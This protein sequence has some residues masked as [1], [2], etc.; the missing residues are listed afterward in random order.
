MIAQM[1]HFLI[2]P[3]F[4]DHD[5]S[6][7]AVLLHFLSL[8]VL[9]VAILGTT[10][11]VINGVTISQVL[12]RFLMVT[13]LCI[14]TQFLMR[15]G[16]VGLSSLLFTAL[17][18]VF[19]IISTLLFGSVRSPAFANFLPALVVS[20]LL[21][22]RKGS[23]WGLGFAFVA[24]ASLT[25]LETRGLLP[26]SNAQLTAVG[27]FIGITAGMGLVTVLLELNRTRLNEVLAQL[28]AAN[29][30]LQTAG[31]SLER[32]VIER[33]KALTTSIEVSRRLSTILDQGQLL[34]EV[35]AQ[36][37]GAFNY[38]HVHIYLWD[39]EQEN[40]LMVEGSGEVGQTLLREEHK[41]AAGKGLVGRA[42]ITNTAVLISDVTQD[43]TWLPNPHLPNTKA[44]IAVAI[45]V[46]NEVLG[47]LDVQHNV[48]N[49]LTQID[50]DLLQSIAGQIAVALQNAQRYEEIQQRTR[51]IEESTNFLDSVLENLPMMLFVKDAEKLQ[52][53]RFNKAGEELVGINRNEFLGK[54]DYDFFPK[55]EAD[56][57]VSKDREVLAGQE[58][59]DIPEEPI[60]TDHQGTRILHTRKVPILDRDGKPQ[61]LLGISEDITEQ[62]L[63]EEQLE[64]RIQQLNLL[65]E[66]GHKAEETDSIP[67][68]LQWVSDRLVTAVRHQET[69]I[70]AITLDDQLYGNEQAIHLPRQ[71][72]EGLR[73]SGELVGRIYIAYKSEHDF[74][75]EESALLGSISQRVA[76]YIETQRLIQR[77]R[78]LAA[79]VEN[80][81]DF[82]G[83]GSLAGE[84]LYVN[85]A[86]LQM[87]G[88][89]PDYAL[90]GMDASDFYPPKDAV[91]LIEE[92]I[93]AA[94]QSGSW[95]DE[96]QLLRVD[97]STLPVEETIGVNYDANNQPI[98]FSITMRDITER[99]Q[100]AEILT[101]QATE[102]QTVTEVGTAVAT[103]NDTAQLLQT[104]VNL[105]QSGFN[106]YYAQIFLV[107]VLN[108]VLQMTAGSGEIGKELLQE[109]LIIPMRSAKSLIAQAANMRQGIVASDV[110]SV[111][112]Y[113]PHPL[114]PNTH[115]EIAIPLVAGNTVLGVLDVQADEIGYFSTADLPVYT[116]LAAQVA[117]A[118]QNARQYEET[119][120]AL[121]E[122][123]TLQRNLT[124]EGWQA[125]MTA[126]KR[127]IRGYHAHQNKVDALETVQETDMDVTTIPVTVLG[128]SIGGLTVRG[129][130]S[131]E[132]QTLLDAISQQVGQALERSRL[133]EQTQVALSETEQQAHRLALL[134]QMSAILNAATSL[135]EVYEIAAEQTAE[136][137]GAD[138][139]SLPLLTQDRKNLMIAAFYGEAYEATTGT[140]IPLAEPMKTAI[141]K[142]QVIKTS[143]SGLIRSVL[144]APLYV[145]GQV[146][147]TINVGS[148]RP[149]AYQM[150]DENLM[151][152]V[153]SLLAARLE[154]LRLFRAAQARAD[155]ERRVRTIT[156]KIRQATNREQILQVAQQE[157]GEMLGAKKTAV[158]LGTKQ[159]L[160]N[161]IANVKDPSPD[162]SSPER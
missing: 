161:H 77:T 112:E 132:N 138:R 131:V 122:V 90:E 89:T 56:F 81:P 12:P 17:L 108:D 137:L 38:Y 37:R 160:L 128:Q 97:G 4:D 79:I 158:H 76:N 62:K 103:I 85:P 130:I 144:V 98:S 52:F 114:L 55:E 1:R 156:D 151:L 41:V 58:L 127:P 71:I 116:A 5:K 100:T 150:R 11:A 3:P 102:L 117:V 152:Q 60:H 129:N 33:T 154:N 121:A 87:M 64:S 105:T 19:L 34:E 68:F 28:Q 31:A 125:F 109:N 143:P 95:S 8:T 9:A 93:P 48:L 29:S 22:G 45:S 74:G 70:T 65:S 86:G 23:L 104:V 141:E 126:R 30:Q 140:I 118:L 21:F 18:W 146:I 16:Q 51:E 80:H 25:T 94:L 2:P 69:C 27:M 134:N 73:V 72:V 36:L 148:K 113:L 32:R 83:V 88:Y 147:G 24:G 110:H 119:Q 40:L 42:A 101:K 57:F 10:A 67:Q 84:A 107:D 20:T 50:A 14:L 66:I 49:G 59:I 124:R 139:V 133:A 106:L 142:L 78:L 111:P 120:R 15:R 47:V 44:E 7:R 155:R 75:D 46:G 91:K 153:T 149:N 6:R 82:I 39:D 54:S 35:V 162:N 135:E 145:S 136:I 99:K 96:A 92:G 159:Q 123:Q 26:E 63:I 13:G 53:V 157:I 61:Y 43:T 115:S